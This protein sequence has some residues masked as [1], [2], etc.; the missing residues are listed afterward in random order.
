MCVTE[1]IDSESVS[2]PE[3]FHFV[4][5]FAKKIRMRLMEILDVL[6]I[7]MASPAWAE[8]FMASLVPKQRVQ[9]ELSVG[10]SV[11][12]RPSLTSFGADQPRHRSRRGSRR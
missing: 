7:L 5:D 6:N 4:I 2:M 1:A 9:S 12:Y 8:S 3:V 11:R 10:G